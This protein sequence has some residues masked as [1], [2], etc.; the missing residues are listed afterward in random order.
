LDALFDHLVGQRE[1]LI[2]HVETE[3]FCGLGLTRG[4]A[5]VEVLAEE[6]TP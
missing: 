4:R 3:R 6:G 1:Q 5:S 2:R